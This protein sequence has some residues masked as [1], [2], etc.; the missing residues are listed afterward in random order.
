MIKIEEILSLN[1][2]LEV[3]HNLYK[4]I[5]VI[6]IYLGGAIYLLFVNIK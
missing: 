6:N 3:S 4:L 2:N 5:Y 1:K